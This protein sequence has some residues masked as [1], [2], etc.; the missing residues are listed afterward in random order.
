M[1]RILVTGGKGFIG[2][3][4]IDEL[5]KQNH[6]V[7]TYDH[8]DRII[9]YDGWEK[10]KHVKGSIL[11]KKLITDSISKSDYV[12]HLA[13]IL[14]TSETIDQ[15]YDAVDSNITGALHVLEA[16]KSHKKRGQIITIGGIEWLNPYA[17][18]KLAGEK[19]SLMYSQEFNLDIK[20]V[21]GL[22]TYGSRQK[23]KP[24]RKA[25]P[26]FII[27]ALQNK[28]IEI[29]GNGNQIVDL[30]YVKD[31]VEVMIKAM[32]IKDKI[33]YVI[34][35]GTGVKTSVNELA[36]LIIKLTNSKSEL[37]YLPMR[38]GEPKD[39]VTLGNIQTLKELNFVPSTTL[40]AGLIVTI[41]WYKDFLK[42]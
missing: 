19:F 36:N 2:S 37:K 5:L 22:N 13:G 8:T 29:Y 39:S 42:H 4:L 14:G 40:E 12:F 35:A 24:V 33:P 30:V 3:H 18:T 16:I 11:D 27:N 21:R 32:K 1:A 10:V 26:N 34:D 31:L 28:P 38:P 25:V 23:H 20:V 15:I 17:I 41:P 6:D 9:G 7:T